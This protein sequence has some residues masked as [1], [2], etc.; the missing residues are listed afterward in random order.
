M[1]FSHQTQVVTLNV[2]IGQLPDLDIV[3]ETENTVVFAFLE[4]FVEL[5]PDC[6]CGKIVFDFQLAVNI[7]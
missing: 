5:C 7:F 4:F 6:I 1:V 3:T 2:I